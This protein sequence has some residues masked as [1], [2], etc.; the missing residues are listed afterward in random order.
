M[1][2]DEVSSLASLLIKTN[3]NPKLLSNG[4]KICV[5]HSP[6]IGG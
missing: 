1:D 4:N 3:E 6:A 5:S 2:I